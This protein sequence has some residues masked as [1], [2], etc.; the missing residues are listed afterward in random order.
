VGVFDYGVNLF[1][2]FRNC[3]MAHKKD[4]PLD[5]SEAKQK[6]RE[7][8]RN[9]DYLGTVKKYPM[10]SVGMAFLAGMLWNKARKKAGLPPG[11]LEIVLQ[12]IK[13]L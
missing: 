2:A 7:S 4:R 8:S 9:I 3:D 10:Q 5:V 11:L 6:L 12:V 13:R 1:A